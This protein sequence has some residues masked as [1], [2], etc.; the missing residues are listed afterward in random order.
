[1]T[2]SGTVTDGN[3]GN[4]YS[5]TFVTSANGTITT[6]GLTIIANSTSKVYGTTLTFAGTEFGTTGLQGGETVGS[7]TLTSTGA[8]AAAT[9]A[10]SPYNIT[11]SAATGGTFTP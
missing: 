2:P 8:A 1:M 10:R 6:R 11:P 7:V 5:I 9:V 3:S 4:N